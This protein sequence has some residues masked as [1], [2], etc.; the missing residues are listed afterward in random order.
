[1]TA[2]DTEGPFSETSLSE[3]GV[4]FLQKTAEHF[5]P[6]NDVFDKCMDQKV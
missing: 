1:M 2:A 4:S 3:I 5:R 6:E